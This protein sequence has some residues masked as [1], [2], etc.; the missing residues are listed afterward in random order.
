[1]RRYEKCLM[2]LYEAGIIAGGPGGVQSISIE[3]D[4]DCDRLNCECDCFLVVA[5]HRYR[6]VDAPDGL[7]P[8]EWFSGDTVN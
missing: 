5:G 7:R 2:A 3:H 6:F 4:T 8:E 1:M